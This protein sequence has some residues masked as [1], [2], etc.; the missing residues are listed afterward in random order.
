V[1]GVA[2]RAEVIGKLNADFA[3]PWFGWK[4]D[5]SVAEDLGI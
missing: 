1:V 3:K 2:G 4:K 5:G